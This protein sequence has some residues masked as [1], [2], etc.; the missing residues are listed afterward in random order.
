LLRLGEKYGHERLNAVC[1]TAL[2][3]ELY[4]VYK[5]RRML[6]LGAVMI[7]NGVTSNVIPLAR[8]LRPQSHFAK[9]SQS[10]GDE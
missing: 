1:T 8:Y 2:D 10:Q 7:E 4:D 5:L 6:E 9:N 3:V